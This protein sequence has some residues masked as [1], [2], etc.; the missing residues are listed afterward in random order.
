M[1]RTEARV[2]AALRTV[3]ETAAVPLPREERA[4]EVAVRSGPPL[5]IAMVGQKGIPATFGGIEHHVEEL[6]ARLAAMGHDVTVYCRT[7]YPTEQVDRHRGMR[8]RYLP[9]A[10]TKHLDAIAHSAVSTAAAMFAGHDVVHYHALGPGLLAPLP[11]YLSRAKVVL[12][13]HGLD[14]ERAKWGP[15]ARAV[16]GAAHRMSATVPDRTVVVSK[17]LRQHYADTFGRPAVY[18]PNGVDEPLPRPARRIERE[19]GLTPGSYLLFVGRLVPEKAPDQ[20]IRAYRQVSGDRRLVLVGDS[21]FTDEY[22]GELRR[23]ADTDPRVLFTG[24]AYGDLLGE[25]YSNAAAFVLPSLLEGLPLTLLEA[26][27]YGL[28][29]VVSDIAP[30]REVLGGDGPGRRVFPAGNERALASVLT[31]VL[32]RADAERDGAAR[33][34]AQI[35]AGYQWR[36]AARSV[37][38]VYQDVVRRRSGRQR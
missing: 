32:D 31:G 30:H 37:E 8:L 22:V 34:R 20:L 15:A 9:T 12:T 16:L 23:L 21:S 10:G 19:F 25:L 3:V 2:G 33:V 17:A 27:S 4:G 24:Y 18:I 28:P 14:N 29:L 13:V 6:G 38:R 35:L 36:E 26:A 11:R 1:D 5:R 7:S